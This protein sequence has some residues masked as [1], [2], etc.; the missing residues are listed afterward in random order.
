MKL[1][2]FE[3]TWCATCKA[4][5]RELKKLQDVVIQHVDMDE[6]YAEPLAGKYNVRS[7]PTMIIADDEGNELHR[8]TGLTKADDITYVINHLDE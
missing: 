1:I 4:Q 7:L 8:F 6:D 5:D 3:A 2:K